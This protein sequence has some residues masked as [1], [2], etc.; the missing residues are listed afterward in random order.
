[1]DITSLL[2]SLAGGLLGGNVAG[3]AK[4]DHLGTVGNSVAGLV[5]G[6][7]ANIVL[8]SLGLLTPET[9]LTVRSIITN[10]AGSGLLG[11]VLPFAVSFLKKSF[12]QR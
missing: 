1:M 12:E 7:L 3:Q 4:A 2:I 9:E 5:G 11:A 6:G 8:H 10:L